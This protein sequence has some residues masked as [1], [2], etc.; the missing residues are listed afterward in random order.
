[1]QHPEI[2]SECLIDRYV[3]NTMPPAQRQAFEE[4]FLDCPQCLDQLEAAASLRQAMRESAAEVLVSSPRAEPVRDHRWLWPGVRWVQIGAFAC[5]VFT[6]GT[7]VVFFRQAQTA[8]TELASARS[9]YGR[10]L[11][12]QKG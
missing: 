6:A 11:E 2:E 3:R 5:L 10:L 7:S 12:N 8:R 4:H 9:D 1:M